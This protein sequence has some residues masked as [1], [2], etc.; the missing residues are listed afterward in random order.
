MHAIIPAAVHVAV[1][2]A[3]LLLLGLIAVVLAW[4]FLCFRLGLWLAGGCGAP[5]HYRH[6]SWCAAEHRP[7]PAPNRPQYNPPPRRDRPSSAVGLILILLLACLAIFG[8]KTRN[9]H[10]A[11]A[12]R[13]P[14][15][16][17]AARPGEEAKHPAWTCTGYGVTDKDA[18]QVALD[19]GYLKVIGYVKDQ[20]P[21]PHWLPSNDYVRTRLKKSSRTEE[22]QLPDLKS[23]QKATVQIELT[24]EDQRDILR[25]GRMLLLMKILGSAIL[26]LGSVAVFIRL[27][28]ASKGYYTGWLSVAILGIVVLAIVSLLL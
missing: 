19:E 8:L 18:E 27:D 28:E 25:R 6:A 11:F 20:L 3:A 13:V 21:P 5:R 4:C 16:K 24:A 14:A 1:P 23:A 26:L 17:A 2:G 7:A 10:H 22:T 12:A 9:M 15:E